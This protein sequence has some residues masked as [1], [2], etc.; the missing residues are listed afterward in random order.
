MLSNNYFYVYTL[1]KFYKYFT[2]KYMYYIGLGY[3][4]EDRIKINVATQ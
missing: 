2:Y 3:V 4:G 1:S